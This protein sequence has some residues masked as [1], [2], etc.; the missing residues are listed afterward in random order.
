MESP[1]ELDTFTENGNSDRDNVQ[2]SGDRVDENDHGHQST[3]DAKEPVDTKGLVDAKRL[4]DAKVPVDTKVLL[5]VTAMGKIPLKIQ[6]FH[7]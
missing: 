2:E 1:K 6:I 5:K 4:M 3:L 7:H